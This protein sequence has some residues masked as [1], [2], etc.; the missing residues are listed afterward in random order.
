[1]LWEVRRRWRK[2]YRIPILL[3]H[4]VMSLQHQQR[5]WAVADIISESTTDR[6]SRW[7]KE[8]GS[9][10]SAA[11]RTSCPTVRRVRR[12]EGGKERGR[13]RTRGRKWVDDRLDRSRMYSWTL[14]LSFGSY[15]AIYRY[16]A[17]PLDLR[18][19]SVRLRHVGRVAARGKRKRESDKEKSV[20]MYVCVCVCRGEASA[21]MNQAPLRS[22]PERFWPQLAGKSTGHQCLRYRVRSC[23]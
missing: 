19:R 7:K 22:C 16:S 4:F 11:S 1:M 6:A 2:P 17:V 12:I 20:F 5:C 9:A 18:E 21:V 15:R 14:L 23:P 8:N 13:G 3:R 10:A